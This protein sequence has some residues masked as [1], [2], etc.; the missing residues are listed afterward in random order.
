ME[1]DHL[2]ILTTTNAPEINAVC[3]VG[4]TEGTPNIHHGQGTA[5]RRIFF[6]N[7]MLEFLWVQNEAEVLS[8]AIAATWLWERW[9][10]RQTGYAP[11]GIALRPTTPQPQLPFATWPFHPPYLPPDLHIPVASDTTPYEPL[12]FMIPF[13]MRPDAF[14]P[15]HRQ[16][17]DHPAGLCEVTRVHINLPTLEPI[18]P[19]MHILH[20]HGLVTYSTHNDYL[21]EIEFDR[22]RQSKMADFRPGLP[23]QLRW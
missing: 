20:T 19:A 3:A 4:L 12:I 2:F 7:A 14:A 22:G 15:Q 13:G 11:F 10:Y 1:C 16:P 8:P 21:T 9:H 5:C 23:L 17:L 6:R 18:S